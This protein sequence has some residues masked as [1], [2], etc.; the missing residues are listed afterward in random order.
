MYNVGDE[1]VPCV[2]QEMP[3]GKGG[4]IVNVMIR[5]SDKTKEWTQQM[6]IRH[7]V[8]EPH[9]VEDIVQCKGPGGWW[10]GHVTKIISSKH[11][12]QGTY[13]VRPEDPSWTKGV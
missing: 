1:L 11:E 12:G 7:V 13:V 9:K 4:S 8:A 10:K 6:D 3:K 5:R 2:V